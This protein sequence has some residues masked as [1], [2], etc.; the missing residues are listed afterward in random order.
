MSSKASVVYA[1]EPDPRVRSVLERNVL[2]RSNIRIVPCA[3]GAA[4]GKARFTLEGHT[5][6]SHLSRATD[7]E[8]N[9]VEVEVITVDSF[10]AQNRLR[11]EAIKIDAE[12]FDTAVIAGS[13]NVLSEQEP[14]VLT[15]AKPQKD[16]FDLILN[17]S[18]RVF[19]YVRHAESRKKVFAE[20]N[21]DSPV[22]GH[23]KMLFLVP[24]RLAGEF[25]RKV[26]AAG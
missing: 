1:F 4:A 10:V 20:L 18:Y 14:V 6:L 21:R 25:E 17:G 5:E 12:G 3:A 26:K 9:Q 13:L 7:A 23:T 11:V 24:R 2:G 15:E 16:L 22:E 19:A 8:A